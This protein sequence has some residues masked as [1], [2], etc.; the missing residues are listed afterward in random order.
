MYK[1]I[2]LF[3]SFVFCVTFALDT[4]YVSRILLLLVYPLLLKNYVVIQESLEL[5]S[6]AAARDPEM[7]TCCTGIST[8]FENF[9]LLWHLLR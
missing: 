7:S 1:C 3:S 2:V 9:D 6:S 5:F 8:Q 4:W